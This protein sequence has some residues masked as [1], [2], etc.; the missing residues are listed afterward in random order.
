MTANAEDPTGAAG[1]A[2]DTGY[3]LVLEPSPRR[4]RAVFAG[5]TIADSRRIPRPGPEPGRRR[6]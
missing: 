4:V 6:R 1:R 2:A 5:E 3:T